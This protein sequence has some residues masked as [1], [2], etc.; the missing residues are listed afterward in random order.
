MGRILAFDDPPAHSSL[1]GE[2][3]NGGDVVMKQGIC[4]G[5][6]RTVSCIA[7]QCLPPNLGSAGHAAE[8]RTPGSR[9]KGQ[10]CCPSHSRH[11]SASQSPAS[12]WEGRSRTPR[13]NPNFC[14]FPSLNGLMIFKR[15]LKGNISHVRSPPATN[16]NPFLPVHE[17]GN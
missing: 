13:Q 1:A 7:V 4:L 11:F 15:S 2:K 3:D 14:V 12:L 9:G 8:L 17:W 16:E 6:K 10:T 5:V